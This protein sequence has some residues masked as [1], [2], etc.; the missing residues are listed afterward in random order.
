M[1]KQLIIVRND[2]HVWLSVSPNLMK[3]NHEE[4][5]EHFISLANVQRLLKP[6]LNTELRIYTQG[7]EGDSITYKRT[8]RKMF[9]QVGLTVVG[10]GF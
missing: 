9:N 6:F 4:I 5:K 1:K 2:T 7:F 10:S 8:E 3:M